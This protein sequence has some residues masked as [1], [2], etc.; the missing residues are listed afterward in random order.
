MG[1]AASGDDALPKDRSPAIRVLAMPAD[2]NA[3][4]DI[5]GG[6]LMSQ[7]DIAGSIVALQRARGRIVTVAVNEFLFLKPVFVGDLISL[8][9]D[10]TRV[11]NT[12]ISVRV[13]GFAQRN[14][15]SLEV[16]RVCEA[17]LTYVAIDEN[18][19]PRPISEN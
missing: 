3:A 14:R 1:G 6:W 9:A 2:T 15:M 13:E 10:V 17:V 11:G 19:R 5:F 7:V 12:S 8:Y 4:G 16:E 18:R